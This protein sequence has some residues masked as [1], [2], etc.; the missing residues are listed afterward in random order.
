MPTQS[1]LV[2]PKIVQN[3][4]QQKAQEKKHTAGKLIT[5]CSFF[6]AL[7]RDRAAGNRG[8]DMTGDVM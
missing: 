6:D 2:K 7:S 8:L 4:R 3:R 5:N 1:K